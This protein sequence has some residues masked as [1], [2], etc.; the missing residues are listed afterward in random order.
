MHRG[1][2]L[3]MSTGVVL[4]TVTAGL[5]FSACSSKVAIGEAVAS[6]DGT[7]VFLALDSCG[8]TYDV[9][10]KESADAVSVAVTDQRPGLR[11]S[12]DACQ[13]GWTLQLTEPLGD[14]ELIDGGRNVALDVLYE[15]WNQQ[16][17]SEAEYRAALEATVSCILAADPEVDASV[18]DGPT[19]PYLT[20]DL[21]D[22]P[23]GQS[24]V[25]PDPDFE[26]S[27]THLD[28]LRR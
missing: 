9:V 20:V 7:R 21:G 3:T 6:G 19:G 14:R 8:G 10:V 4:W 15:P 16:R 28:P 11:L 22:L 27:M 23:D 12:G 5:L 17:F 26:C 24:R 18:V 1:R 2:A 25:G 13:E